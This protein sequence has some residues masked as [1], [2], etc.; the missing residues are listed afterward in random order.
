VWGRIDKP[1]KSNPFENVFK[2][3]SGRKI[4]ALQLQTVGKTTS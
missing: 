3:L 2:N 4:L 1:K